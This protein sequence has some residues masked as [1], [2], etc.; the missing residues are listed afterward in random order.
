[1]EHFKETFLPAGKK[2]W[3]GH[4]THKLTTRTFPLKAQ[5]SMPP[6]SGP[7]ASR[8]S[9]SSEQPVPDEFSD[10]SDSGFGLFLL[11]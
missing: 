7:W 1:M 4:C 2:I 5:E 8:S 6:N 3:N 10:F 11:C 9:H